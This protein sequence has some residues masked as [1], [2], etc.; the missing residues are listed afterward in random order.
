MDDDD[1]YKTPLI[2][3]LGSIALGLIVIAAII[4][5]LSGCPGTKKDETVPVEPITGP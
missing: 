3:T 1:R 5:F 2:A 4:I